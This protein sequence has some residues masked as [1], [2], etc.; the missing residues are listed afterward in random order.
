MDRGE[1]LFRFRS[2]KAT[3]IDFFAKI[4]INSRSIHATDLV[5]VFTYFFTSQKY[6]FSEKN[7]IFGKRK[8]TKL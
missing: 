7:C 3:P 6:I 5:Y 1:L 4:L 8:P 2:L